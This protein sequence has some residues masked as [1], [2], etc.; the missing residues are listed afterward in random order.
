MINADNEAPIV[1]CPNNVPMM[2]VDPGVADAIVTWS[3]LPSAND[4][5]DGVIAPSSIVCE[6][7]PGNAVMSGDR[8]AVG[9]TT[10]TCRANDSVPLEGNCQFNITVVGKCCQSDL[11]K[12]IYFIMDILFIC[13]FP[14]FKR[15]VNRYISSL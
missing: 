3:P 13:N 2:N 9:T 5:I 10:V 12:N 7:G 6:V 15:N 1:Y 8:F 14:Q 11:I 4:T